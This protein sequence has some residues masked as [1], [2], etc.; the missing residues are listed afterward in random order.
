MAKKKEVEENVFSFSEND[1]TITEQE[2]SNEMQ[3][4]MLP[5]NFDLQTLVDSLNVLINSIEYAQSKGVYP[6][7]MASDIYNSIM[8][9]QKM[10]E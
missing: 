9:I 8:S 1:V 3:Q 7:S 10:F 2:H 6:L 5:Q 4:Q